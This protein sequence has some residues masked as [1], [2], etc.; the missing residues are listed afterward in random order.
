MGIQENHVDTT[1]NCYGALDG[2]Y[3]LLMGAAANY[4][5]Y[6][7]SEMEKGV[8][9]TD[10]GYM[11]HLFETFMEFQLVF[12]NMYA[13]CYFEL[14]LMQFGKIFNTA[15]GAGNWISAIFWIVYEYYDEQTGNVV[16]LEAALKTTDSQSKGL[17]LGMIFSELMDWEVP[18]YKV[19]EFGK[20]S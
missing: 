2:V 14:L 4:D 16:L 9:A 1:S 18:V 7:A 20:A 19:N 11:I 12:F 15:S 8:S 13:N 3:A 5:A 17:Y 10:S 6:A